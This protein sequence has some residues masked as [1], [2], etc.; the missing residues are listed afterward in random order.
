MDIG[1]KQG[2][3]VIEDVENPEPVLTP[4]V[5][6]VWD[7]VVAMDLEAQSAAFCIS[8]LLRDESE[9]VCNCQVAACLG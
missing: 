9:W 1:D 2:A 3:V 8:C 5:P 7:A 6:E 4:V